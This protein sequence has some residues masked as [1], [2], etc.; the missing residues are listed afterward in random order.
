[1]ARTMLL[2]VALIAL[3]APAHAGIRSPE[4]GLHLDLEAVTDF[5]LD[6]GGR[7]ALECPYRIRVATALGVL[8]AG[9]LDAINGVVVAAGGYDD[10]TAEL[11]RTTLRNSL[12]WRL[13]VG[14]RPLADYG[15]YFEVGYAIVTL[16]GA[17]DSEDL[18]VLATGADESEMSRTRTYEVAS[19][20]HQLVGEVG[21]QWILWEQLDL[22]VALGFAGTVASSTDVG[23]KSRQPP[24]PR[25]AT[26]EA[27]SE[28]YLDDVYTSYVFT[29]TVTVAVGYRFF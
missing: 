16:G 18:L 13:Q 21:W 5:P 11:V 9:Y 4:A 10:A 22:R 7:I 14:W 17:V 15:F 24:G 25:L 3:A 20:L 2:L 12:V 1:M 26:L 28:A 8:P 23:R 29:P 19:T 27:D 6:V